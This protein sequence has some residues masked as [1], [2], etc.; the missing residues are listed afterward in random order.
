MGHRAIHPGLAA[1]SA[2][3]MPEYFGFLRRIGGK[4]AS[5]VNIPKQR[6]HRFKRRALGQ[7]DGAAAPIERPSLIDEGNFAL[8]MRSPNHRGKPWNAS[9]QAFDIG[10]PV[11]MLA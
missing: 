4:G 7:F 5:L 8:P 6:R 2:V 11:A 9:Q 1:E 10:P 3:Q